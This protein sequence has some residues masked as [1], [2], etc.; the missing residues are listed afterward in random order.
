MPPTPLIIQLPHWTFKSFPTERSQVWLNRSLI[1]TAL[2]PLKPSIVNLEGGKVFT[3]EHFPEQYPD[4]W[5]KGRRFS[6]SYCEPLMAAL[7]Q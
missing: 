1:K 3:P 7:N 4:L 2:G 5:E 6:R